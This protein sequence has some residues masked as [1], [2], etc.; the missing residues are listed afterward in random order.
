MDTDLK[1]GLGGAARSY[2]KPAWV[3]E[4][5]NVFMVLCVL[6]GRLPD[7]GVST[8][9]PLSGAAVG[10]SFPKNPK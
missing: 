4:W 5:R 2:M 1:S 9:A 7:P 6:I 8:P 3:Q 10:V